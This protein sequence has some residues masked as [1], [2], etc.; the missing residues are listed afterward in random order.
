MWTAD[1]AHRSRHGE[2]GLTL[3][4]AVIT[5]GLL[6]LLAITIERTLFTAHDASVTLDAMRRVQQRADE[7]AY[8][9][10]AHVS[11]AR[12]LFFRGTVGNQYL[13]ALDLDRFPPAPGARLPLPDEDDPLGPDQEGVP[14][15]SNVL[16]FVRESDPFVCPADA[17]GKIRYIDVYR[18]VAVYPHEASPTHIVQADAQDA[19][20]L[21]VWMSVG[22]PSYPQILSVE[23]EDERRRVVQE[24]VSAYGYEKAWNPDGAFADAFFSLDALGNVSATAEPP[25]DIDED[26]AESPGGRLVYANYQLARTDAASFVR[27]ARL[28]RDDP[29]TWVPDGFEVK[30]VGPSGMRQVWMRFTVETQSA[31]ARDVVHGST[32]IATIRDL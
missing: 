3:L 7:V 32:L 22:F 20:D 28:T 11:A 18:F 26:L 4:E 27:R 24:L 13:L 17:S 30:V 21:V 14:R 10:H 25:E 29:E 2:R 19:R 8:E 16:L 9:V 12:R 15:T 1:P 31:T 5:L 23:D 6:G